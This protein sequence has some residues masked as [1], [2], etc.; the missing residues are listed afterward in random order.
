MELLTAVNLIL[1]ALGEHPVTRVDMKHPTLAVILPVVQSQ[2]D[3][4]LMRGWWFN[5][6]PTTL[7]PD[8]EGGIAI[9]SDTLAFIPQEGQPG[10]VRNG[11]L[12]NT[13]SL[14]YIWDKPVPGTIQLRMSFEELP[15]SVATYVFYNALVQTYLVDI[16]LESVVGEWKQ[17][18]K[19]SEFLATNEHLRNMRHTTRK[20]GRYA[21]LRSAM[22]S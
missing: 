1:P 9:P 8:S 21:R 14:D 10:T 19:E 12:F 18:A 15:E 2:I 20:S 5:E 17:I 6:F 13:T 3:R 22:R 7:Y 16:G 11:V 4:C